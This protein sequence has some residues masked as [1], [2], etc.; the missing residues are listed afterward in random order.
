MAFAQATETWVV[1]APVALLY[2]LPDSASPSAG[3]VVKGRQLKATGDRTNG[4][5]NLS[6]KSGKKLWVRQTD[7]ASVTAT[8]DDQEGRLEKIAGPADAPAKPK[9]VVRQVAV[10]AD[11]ARDWSFHYP[12]RATFDLGG[13]VGSYTAGGT[14]Y[15][16]TE[17]D[18]GLNL[19]FADWLDWRN[20]PFARFG[21]QASNLYGLDSTLRGILSMG[22]QELGATFFAG[23]GW[24]FTNTGNDV[25]FAEAGLV[26][27]FS[28]VAVGGGLRTFLQS[29][30]GANSTNDTQYFLILSGGGNL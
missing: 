10:Q 7:L 6:T 9:P 3:Q 26:L 1:S 16:Y 18:V 20:A 25:P 14:S 29:W 15:S 12:P 22:G 23:P 24:R 4:F 11:S 19:Y 13:S 2:S 28:Q 30:V 27:K 5:I 8:D 21:S 17:I